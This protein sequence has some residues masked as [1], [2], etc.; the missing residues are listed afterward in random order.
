MIELDDKSYIV[1][2][3]FSS[4]PKTND[5]WMACVIR[6][7]SKGINKNLIRSDNELYYKGT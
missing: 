7:E 2:M 3:W 6:E 4:N 1:G 5:D